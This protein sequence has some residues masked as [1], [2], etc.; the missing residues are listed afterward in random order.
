MVLV[1]MSKEL[2]HRALKRAICSFQ[3]FPSVRTTNAHHPDT[4]RPACPWSFSCRSG[5]PLWRQ[6]PVRWGSHK[7]ICFLELKGF[8]I[9]NHMELKW[10]TNNIH[11]SS[12]MTS[13]YHCFSTTIT[14]SFPITLKSN[15]MQETA[16]IWLHLNFIT[17]IIH[18]YI[19]ILMYVSPLCPEIHSAFY[20]KRSFTFYSSDEIIW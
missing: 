3:D 12:T 9:I 11:P 16:W 17:S 14:T 20:Q 1:S 15:N 19:N 7:A 10:T 13:I 18:I 6:K 2:Y 4:S 5:C 8:I